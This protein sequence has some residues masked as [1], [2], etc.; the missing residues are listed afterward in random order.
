MKGESLQKG[1][2]EQDAIDQKKLRSETKK[3]QR[4]VCKKGKVSSD[5]GKFSTK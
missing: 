3:G 4:P 1:L 5:R 2:T